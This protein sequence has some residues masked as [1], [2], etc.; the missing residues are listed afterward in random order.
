MSPLLSA[1]NHSQANNNA[2]SLNRAVPKAVNVLCITMNVATL[3]H[4]MKDIEPASTHTHPKHSTAFKG[5]LNRLLATTGVMRF[6]MMS[7]EKYSHS[8]MEGDTEYFSIW[9]L[10]YVYKY[11]LKKSH[12]SVWPLASIR[13][14]T[15]T[16]ALY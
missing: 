13:Q 8:S 14:K 15:T 10:K 4:M 5:V 7:M 2:V 1:E 6:C 12:A 3:L 9:K 11:L 16:K